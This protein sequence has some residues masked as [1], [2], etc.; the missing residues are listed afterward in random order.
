VNLFEE[1]PELR[2][3]TDVIENDK[4][5]TVKAELPG[6]KK[7]DIQVTVDGNQLVIKAEVKKEK[8]EKKD[9]KIIHCE[10][11]YG[12][13]YRGLRLNQDVNEADV[14][15]KYQDGV[16]ELTLPKKAGSTSKQ[17]NIQ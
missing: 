2:I 17:I 11:Y 1:N 10:R 16:L 12:Q 4:A 5:Y 8:E 13:I 7:E 9:E 6:V 3:K 15:A 14:Y